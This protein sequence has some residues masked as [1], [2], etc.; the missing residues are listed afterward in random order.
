MATYKKST[1]TDPTKATYGE[2]S[3]GVSA[4]QRQ[5]NQKY[6]GTQ[7]YTPLKEDGKYGPLTQAASKF[8]APTATTTPAPDPVTEG[9]RR[10]ISGLLAG[11]KNQY[12]T[13]DDYYNSV[14]GKQPKF[15]D[16][17]RQELGNVQGIID[18]VNQQYAG[19]VARAKESGIGRMGQ[20]RSIQARSGNLGSSFGAGALNQTQDYNDEVIQQ[21]EAE[22]AAKVQAILYDARMFAQ[23][24]FEDQRAQIEK[25]GDAFLEYQKEQV[26]K[27]R[28]NVKTLASTGVAL[29]DIPDEDYKNL[30]QAAGFDNQLLFE[31]YYNANKPK[32]EQIDYKYFN[33][34]NGK[35]VRFDDQGGEPTEFS[36]DVPKDY[37]FTFAPD[38]TPFMYNDAG[39]AMVAPGF[40]KGQFA[41]PTAGD[42]GEDA[43]IT[44]ELQAAQEAIDGGA[45][46]D[47]V[48]RRFLDAYPK[49]GE[50]FLKYTKQEF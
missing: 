20:T 39:E 2:F 32:E 12:E 22:K 18:A 16:V 23:K 27:M 28:E 40:S 29:E 7:G 24:S 1:N 33:L 19:T 47:Q 9:K 11:T 4:L 46:P 49:K 36:F 41:K 48:R 8:Q 13:A 45:D 14:Y 35:M 17:L 26:T 5:L 30:F 15:E 10:D 37:K 34:G 38:G 43:E 44:K 21:I 50:L 25:K 6:T 3:S 31:G 42:D